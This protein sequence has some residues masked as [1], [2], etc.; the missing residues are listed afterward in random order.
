[1]PEIPQ[2]IQDQAGAIQSNFNATVTQVRS[3]GD[4]TEDAKLRR[5]ARAWTDAEA[6]MGELRQSWQGRSTESAESLTKQV[7]GAA[8]TSGADA[9]S[10]RDADDRASR[11]EDADEALSLL[12]RAEDNGDV[13]LSRAIALHAFGKRN[14]F[15]GG[16]WAG[17]VDAYA[18]AHPQ[19]AEKIVKLATLRTDTINTSVASAFVFSIFKPSE[20]DRVRST[21]LT[22]LLADR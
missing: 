6:R 7:F 1:M 21:Q 10:V 19:V 12:R 13:V 9:I 3:N 11:L 22:A 2:N 20:L 4:L 18:E 17:V 15:F 5:L 14:E 8:G 16:D